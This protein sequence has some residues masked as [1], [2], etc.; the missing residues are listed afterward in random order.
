MGIGDTILKVLITVESGGEYIGDYYV[1][2]NFEN[3]HNTFFLK[4]ANLP[5]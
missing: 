5:G 1:S 2:F 4:L 3:V